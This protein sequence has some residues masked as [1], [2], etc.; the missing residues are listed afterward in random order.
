LVP[1]M[2]TSPGTRVMYE[3]MKARTSTTLYSMSLVV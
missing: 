3:L 2:M 1:H